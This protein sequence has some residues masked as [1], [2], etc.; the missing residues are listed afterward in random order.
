M[1]LLAAGIFVVG[2]LLRANTVV[3]RLAMQ[4]AVSYANCSDTASGVCLT[5]LNEYGTAA[6]LANIAPQ[7]TAANL[8]LTIAQVTMNGT[9]P[10]VEYPVGLTLT[11]AQTGALQAVVASGQSGTVQTAVVVTAQYSY[12][13]MFFAPLMTPIIGASVTLSYTAAQLK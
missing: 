6:A 8:T 1:L 12:L 3:N 9:T 7:L 11:S 2:S 4:Y 5:E 13:P 10:T